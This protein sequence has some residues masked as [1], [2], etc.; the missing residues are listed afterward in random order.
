MNRILTIFL[1]SICSLTMLGQRTIE[2]NSIPQPQQI[3]LTGKDAFLLQNGM[4][5]ICQNEDAQMTYN[6]QLLQKCLKDYCSLDCNVTAEGNKKNAILLKTKEN[7]GQSDEAYSIKIDKRNVTIEGSSPIGVFY[8]IQTLCQSIGQGEGPVVLPSVSITDSPRF[9]YRG[10]MLDFSRHFFDKAFVMKQIEAMSHYKLNR[11]HMHLTDA[12]GWRIEIKSHPELTRGTA[13]RTRENWREWW[14]RSNDRHYVDEGT[15]GAYGGYFT[16]D[17]IREIVQFASKHGITIIP[18]I[19]MPG[20]CQ[21]VFFVHPELCCTG[22]FLKQGDV[23]IGNDAIFPF[24]EDV[25]KEIASLFPS[26][27]IH[28][29]GDECSMHTWPD[30]PKCQKRMKDEGL[31]KVADLQ[32]WFVN[33]MD[34]FIGSLGKKIIGWD[35]ILD[36]DLSQGAAV[37]SWRGTEGGIKAASQGHHVVMSPDEPLYLDKYQ[38]SPAVCP[39]A[40][41]GLNNLEKVYAYDPEG[42]VPQDKTGFVDG[43]QGNLWTE[44]VPTAEHAEYMMWPRLMAIAERG[45]SREDCNDYTDFRKRAL[46]EVSKLQKDGYHPFDLKN[47]TLQK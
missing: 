29:G 36:G 32:T 30:C 14:D 4:E 19:E 2:Y 23:C 17:D 8:G 12:G 39:E 20:H 7:D 31:E 22:N 43:L 37:M 34:K 11:L 6:A 28:M 16:Q 46:R 24:F 33:K 27:Y 40:Q 47:E 9:P 18:E 41:E 3:R 5:I 38:D 1:L 10:F 45:W 21:D 15:E 13:Y 25:L 44:R 26:E 42:G 35:E